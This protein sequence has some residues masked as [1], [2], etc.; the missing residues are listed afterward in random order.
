MQSYKVFIENYTIR[1][2]ESEKTMKKG[3]IFFKDS[4]FSKDTFINNVISNLNNI[5]V[6]VICF[7]PYV[8]FLHFKNQFDQIDAAGGI[9]FN[10]AN[11]KYLF[12]KRLGVWDLPK[13]KFEKEDKVLMSCAVRAVSE[14]C[15]IPTSSLKIQHTSPIITSHYYFCLYTNRHIIKN[16]YWYRME[17]ETVYLTP[18][19]EEDIDLCNWFSKDEING[20]VLK[21]TY[22]SINEV[23]KICFLI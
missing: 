8:S 23:L 4:E 9:V 15:G 18:Q 1:F 7:D 10:S 2:I 3:A 16:T 19:L 20:V 11:C 12:I 6:Y 5:D 21:N 13:G 14:E 17:T 22:S